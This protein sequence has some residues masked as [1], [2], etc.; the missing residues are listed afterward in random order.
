MGCFGVALACCPV[1][2]AGAPALGLAEMVFTADVTE[3]KA[4][5]LSLVNYCD[6]QEH[7]IILYK[8]AE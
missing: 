7:S 4:R 8:Q 5:N 2:P 3:N 1:T 6:N